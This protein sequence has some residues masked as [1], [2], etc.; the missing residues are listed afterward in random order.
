[1]IRVKNNLTGQTGS[2]PEENFNPMKYTRFEEAGVMP[3]NNIP[4]P[5]LM[6]KGI[7]GLRNLLPTAGMLAGG[8]GGTAI[9]GPVLGA[10]GAGI[11][12]TA[13]Y[14][15]NDVLKSLLGE[16]RPSAQEAL[17][18]GSQSFG[19]G[20]LSELFGQGVGA[21]GGK[22]LGPATSKIKFGTSKTVQ[23]SIET[24]LD[25][26]GKEIEDLLSPLQEK[27]ID[28]KPIVGNLIKLKDKEAFRND[29]TAVEKVNSVIAWLK[30]FNEKDFTSKQLSSIPGNISPYKAYELS[31]K[32]G[33]ELASL[34]NKDVSDVRGEA[35][36]AWIKAEK[37]AGGGL[38]TEVKNI[39]GTSELMEKYQQFKNIQDKMKNPFG[40]Y[41]KGQAM[42]NILGGLIGGAGGYGL[43][44][45][46]Q[47]L[48]LGSSLGAL[49]MMPYT[50]FLGQKLIGRGL[51][52]GKAPSE[53]ALFN[54]LNM[55]GEQ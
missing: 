19:T 8:V 26:I 21:V 55:G 13:G 34:F 36:K 15:I 31:K 5:S 38:R 47:G 54:L 51:E 44:G 46:P 35:K 7:S 40:E 32:S 9:G 37:I 33:S 22:I 17:Q 3:Q 1:M 16:Q 23:S 18:Q 45:G 41:W 14:G 48:M 12:A 43:L 53:A 52:L 6:E 30:G 20:A 49:S 11:G 2:M 24:N 29:P 28:I 27:N 50:K 4:E 42:M 10:A 39:P 25:K